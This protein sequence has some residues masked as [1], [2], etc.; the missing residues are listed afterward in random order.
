MIGLGT[1]GLEAQRKEVSV[2]DD[3]GRHSFASHCAGCHGLDGRGGERAPDIATQKDVQRFSDAALSRIIQDGISGTGMPAF[4]QLGKSRIEAI[5]GYLRTLQ[6]TAGTGSVTGNP[7][8]GKKLFFGIAQ[9][10][11]C[12][13]MQGEGHGIASDLSGYAGNRSADQIRESLASAGAMGTRAHKLVAVTAQDGQRLEGVIRNEDNFSMQ[14]QTLDGAF[15]SVSKPYL[16][17]VPFS[18]PV[19]LSD[20]VAKLSQRDLDDVVSYLMSVGRSKG[21]ERRPA[22]PRKNKDQNRKDSE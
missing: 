6:G 5:V 17:D 1:T 18:K 13:T 19:L 11:T 7:T 2:A 20:Y 12:H 22:S 4:R 8:A 9:C 21:D 10:S 3:A 14:L 15:H 16:E